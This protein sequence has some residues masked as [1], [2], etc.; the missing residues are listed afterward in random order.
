MT[1]DAKGVTGLGLRGAQIW[2]RGNPRPRG[3][4]GAFPGQEQRPLSDWPAGCLP[5]AWPLL[6]MLEGG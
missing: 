4:E 5:P 1:E 6:L 3:R 2:G